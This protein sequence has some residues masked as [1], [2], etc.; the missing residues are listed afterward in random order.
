[1]IT[2]VT[3]I[4]QFTIDHDGKRVL[5]ICFS[6]GDIVQFKSTRRYFTDG[7]VFKTFKEQRNFFNGVPRSL[8]G[9]INELD[10]RSELTR[11]ISQD[12]VKSGMDFLLS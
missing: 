10:V 3:K 2:T 5:E 9:Q 7:S 8:K 4:D 11:W 6:T 1:M 12:Q